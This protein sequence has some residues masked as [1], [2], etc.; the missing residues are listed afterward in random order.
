MVKD[1]LPDSNG[2][3]E[4]F[5]LLGGIFKDGM[6]WNDY[7]FSFD[8]E[9][10]KSN[11]KYI[12]ALR[13]CI[14]E[15]NLRK[16]GAWHQYEGNP[17]FSDNTVAIFSFRAWGDLMAAIWSTEENRDYN[18]MDFYYTNNGERYDNM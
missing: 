3:K 14:I 1:W 17:L 16:G 11:Q 5:I 2:Y 9:W 15:N 4:S 12:D 8:P 6:R 10:S 7:I 18:Y 13:L